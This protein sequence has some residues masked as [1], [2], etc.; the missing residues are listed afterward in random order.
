MFTEPRASY[1]RARVSDAE[2]RAILAAAR[3]RNITVSDLI[4]E[5]AGRSTRSGNPTQSA[6][7]HVSMG[8][9]N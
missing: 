8:R 3:R 1:V 7:L 2:K 4:R 6:S 5:A 9:A